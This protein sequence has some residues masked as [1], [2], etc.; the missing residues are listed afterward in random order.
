[1]CPAFLACVNQF[2]HVG[3]RLCEWKKVNECVGENR[4]CRLL[5]RHCCSCS[6]VAS[7]SFDSGGAPSLFTSA[8]R[9][10][11][12]VSSSCEQLDDRV[13]RLL[14]W[15]LRSYLWPVT[16][17]G[18]LRCRFAYFRQPMSESAY[19]CTLTDALSCVCIH[20]C[21]CDARVKKAL[22]DIILKCDSY[23]LRSLWSES[24]RTHW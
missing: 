2:I 17:T 22:S 20:M 11:T 14:P 9:C 10:C 19:L 5:I 23:T 13:N 21:V 4:Y 7:F 16:I 18:S 1:M 12:S 24:T 8:G 15:E 6:S 3:V